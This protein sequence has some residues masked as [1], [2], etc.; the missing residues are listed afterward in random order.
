MSITIF[1]MLNGLGVCFLLYVLANFW[2]VGRQTKNESTNE[3]T[4]ELTNIDRKYVTQF[5]HRDGANVL[6][7]THPISHSPQGGVSV[8]PFQ[9]RS[10]KAGGKL[11]SRPA[12]RET[13]EIPLR[14]IST[15]SAQ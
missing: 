6:V 13:T 4:N 7:V 1:L 10:R 11:E 9:A 5:R 14:R 2:K 12:A 3:L 15:R 8:I